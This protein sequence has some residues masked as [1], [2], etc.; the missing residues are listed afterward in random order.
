MH[1]GGRQFM[2]ALKQSLM[3]IALLVVSALAAGA[4]GSDPQTKSVAPASTAPESPSVAAPAGTESA[5]TLVETATDNKFGQTNLS[6]RAGEKYTLALR[7]AGQAVHNLR[8]EN[9]KGSDGKDV[10]VPLVEPG[11]TASTTFSVS[12]PGTYQFV[13]DV[14]PAE[15]RGTLTVQQA[16]SAP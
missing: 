5:N 6:I 10:A 1:L 4:C 7:N 15:M 8:I 14:H 11:K 3:V 12:A 2:R 9:V 13:C 16:S